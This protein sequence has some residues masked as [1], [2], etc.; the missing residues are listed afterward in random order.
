MFPSL[1]SSRH[2]DH[3]SSLLESSNVELRITV[4]EALV[5]LYEAVYENEELQDESYDIF[6][7]KSRSEIEIHSLD[8]KIKKTKFLVRFKLLE[9]NNSGLAKSRPW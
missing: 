6:A 2:I 9:E 1:F 5:I 3:F 8:R 7:S 4:G